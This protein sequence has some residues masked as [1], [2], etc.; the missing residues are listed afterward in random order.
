[1][2]VI[3]G[4]HGEAFNEREGGGMFHG[5]SIFDESVKVP[6]IILDRRRISSSNSRRTSS[7]NSSS[8]SRRSTGGIGGG[9]SKDSATAAAGARF[10]GGSWSNVDLRTTLLH[11]LGFELPPDSTSSTSSN[12]AAAPS[13]LPKSRDILRW[14][15][16]GAEEQVARRRNSSAALCDVVI[17]SL[18]DKENVACVHDE[19]DNGGVSGRSHRLKL[20]KH[21]EAGGFQ[22]QLFNLTADPIER[23]GAVVAA[24]S[25]FF[26]AAASLL[27]RLPT[28]FSSSATVA[29]GDGD[30]LS[31]AS[32]A[33]RG[34]AEAVRF[35]EQAAQRIEESQWRETRPDIK[36]ALDWNFN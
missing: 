24:G 6:C 19:I 7:S 2:V 13:S 8:S 30:A 32:F 1:M 9:G 34:L 33:E 29:S 5:G 16:G 22:S 28:S 4:D 23:R 21:G 31:L 25:G 36:T 26:L 14:Q 10:V 15:R 12:L 35:R 27:L 11:L 3:A 17:S 20:I 18:L